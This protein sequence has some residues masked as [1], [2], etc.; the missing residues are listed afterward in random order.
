M[1]LERFKGGVDRIGSDSRSHGE[2]QKEPLDA[3][4]EL[5]VPDLRHEK[6]DGGIDECSVATKRSSRS[7]SRQAVSPW[8]VVPR[9][10]PCCERA[11]PERY[12]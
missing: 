10:S 3:G 2:Q 8:G 5:F 6:H 4:F 12:S 11:V 1:G 9:E 7:L